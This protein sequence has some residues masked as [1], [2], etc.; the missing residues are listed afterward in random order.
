MLI[1]EDKN[2][3]GDEKSFGDMSSIMINP[4]QMYNDF[5][6]MEDEQVEQDLDKAANNVHL[7]AKKNSG[8]NTGQN[9]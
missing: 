4:D 8:K 6:L 1:E 3:E 7:P 5:N 9:K 2:E